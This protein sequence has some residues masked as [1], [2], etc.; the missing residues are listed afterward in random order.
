MRFLGST[1]MLEL[2]AKL[3]QQVW[4]E[5]AAEEEVLALVTRTGLHTSMG[6]MLRQVMTPTPSTDP[7]VKVCFTV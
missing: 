4:N 2:T 3:S 6:T 7:F 1:S 5:M